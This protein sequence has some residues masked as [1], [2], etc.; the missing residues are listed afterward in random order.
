MSK[1]L[2]NTDVDVTQSSVSRRRFL[3][4]T[5]WM[6]SAVA[7][8]AGSWLIPARWS[9][10]AGPIKLGIATDITGMMGYAG[11]SHVHVANWLAEEINAGGGINGRP[12]EVHIE[13]TATNDQTAVAVVRKLTQKEN[14]DVIIGGIMSST[15]NAIK[16]VIIERGK[17][18]YVY[19]EVYE[20]GAC[21]PYL[22]CTGPVPSQQI[23]PFIPWL[24]ENGGPRFAFP[25]ANYSWPQITN[26]YARNVVEQ[27]GGEVVFEEYY[28]LDQMD[29]GSTIN[30][31]MKENIDVVFIT[32][33]P[34]G[35]PGFIT[36]LHEA[37]F[38]KR[39]G[40]LACVYYDENMTQVNPAEE[41]EGMASCLDYYR[42]IGEQGW[43][44]ESARIMNE[45]EKR[46]GSDHLFSAGAGSSGM[47]RA[48]KLLEV[49]ITE[50]GS[51]DR[52]DVAAALDHASIDKG[53]G[54]PAKMV[55]GT[56]HCAMNMYIAVAKNG[57]YEIAAKSDG[58][59]TPQECA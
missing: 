26:K 49:A 39:G 41:F 5:A 30:T 46:F 22:Y 23:D 17:T 37:G 52:D 25:A 59:A 44:A 10:A 7:L 12:L 53:P 2:G 42:A 32:L 14:V 45:Y 56:N 28:P 34:P 21:Q 54:G 55:P 6:S 1:K 29:Y 27:S 47:Y 18:L 20:G 15:R 43:D 38:T 51:V 57:S 35:L 31:I 19:P 40:R 48:I 33:I 24:I 13:D 58:L 4:S 8:G 11:N 9:H 36:G 50:A 16:D 3:Q